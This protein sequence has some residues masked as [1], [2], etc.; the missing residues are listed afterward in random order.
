M[1]KEL[2]IT[3]LVIR[4]KSSCFLAGN[5]HFTYLGWVFFRL[6]STLWEFSKEKTFHTRNHEHV[7]TACCFCEEIHDLETV[8]A[9][10]L[11]LAPFLKMLDEVFSIVTTQTNTKSIKSAKKHT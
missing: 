8:K 3:N 4:I 6:A 1:R 5:H 2:C 9:I 11:T 7:N 10:C